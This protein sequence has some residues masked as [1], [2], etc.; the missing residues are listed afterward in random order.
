LIVL[1]VFKLVATV[2]S[3]AS[4]G[5]GGIFAP[6]LFIGGMLGGLFGRGLFGHAD[7]VLLHHS[8]GEAGAFALV[9]M[10]AVF[11]GIVRAP[12]TSVLIIFEMTG[13][14][15]LILPLMISNRTSTPP[16]AEER[17]TLEG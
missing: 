8:S 14:Y 11:A 15:E 6:S 10:G 5:A 7:M 2:F 16:F 17:E 1:C 3:Y 4:G 12:M 13:S 9:G